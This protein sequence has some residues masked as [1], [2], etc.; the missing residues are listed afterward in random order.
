MLAWV[1][2]PMKPGLPFPKGCFVCRDKQF[3]KEDTMGST[4]DIRSLQIYS[5][6]RIIPIGPV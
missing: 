2:I 3:F 6:G 1:W 5:I 4:E